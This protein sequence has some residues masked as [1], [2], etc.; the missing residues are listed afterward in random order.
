MNRS[1]TWLF[2]AVFALAAPARADYLPTPQAAIDAVRNAA[3]VAQARAERDAQALKSAG[4]AGGREEWSVTAD[5]AQRR[6]ETTPRDTVG[7]W[8]L[9]LSRPLRLPA[10]AAAER[11][12]A[13]ALGAY[14]E[15]SFDETVH[16]TGRQ[17]LA[18]WFD[19]LREAAQARLWD[20][21]LALAARQLDAVNVRI[22][23]GEA[24]RAERVSAEAALGQVRLQQRQAAQRAREAQGRLLA[25]FP[26]LPFGAVDTLPEPVSPEGSAEAYV[27]A[28]LA[29]NH[30]LTR[31]RRHAS[32]LQAEARQMAAR[33]HAEPTLGVFY[34]NEAGGNERV[35]GMSVGVALPGAARRSDHESAERLSLAAGMAALQ[36]E[37]RLRQ[38]ARTDFESAVDAVAGWQQAEATAAAL[39][40]AARLAARSYELGEGNLDQVLLARRQATEARMQAR[41]AQV[42][43]LAANARLALDAHRL[44]PNMYD[45][46]AHAAHPD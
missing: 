36:L 29:H 19:W 44:W 40:E 45:D 33:R 26:G 5:L 9:A 15:A 23:L 10:R 34:R 27:E 12:V 32:L 21:Q 3:S 6:V 13:G 14:A 42:A 38:E 2:G 1:L 7:E 11:A 35:L 39:E 46:D 25:Q 20:E 31:A 16:E 18:L 4:L 28:V 24:P 41:Q 37:Q 22:R 17:L 43:A 30:E 8:A